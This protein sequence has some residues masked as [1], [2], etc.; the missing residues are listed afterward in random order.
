MRERG[1]RDMLITE[2]EA[3]LA[4]AS[5]SGEHR[6][7]QRSEPC[8]EGILITED[9]EHPVT[10][11]EAAFGGIRVCARDGFTPELGEMAEIRINMGDDPFHDDC[12]VV[13]TSQEPEGTVIHLAM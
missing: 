13:E 6:H 5:E 8:L 12:L 3:A 1:L 2:V 7:T 9:G 11:I 4:R 10:L